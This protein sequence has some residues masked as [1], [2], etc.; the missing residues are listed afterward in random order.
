MRRLPQRQPLHRKT[1]GITGIRVGSTQPDER[2]RCS[3]RCVPE[4]RERQLARLMD[5]AKGDHD[6]RDWRRREYARLASRFDPLADVPLKVWQEEW[7][8]GK[9]ASADAF[10]RLLGD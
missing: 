2:Y 3:R 6:L 8:P 5:F 4:E 9:S 7:E 10:A 1:L